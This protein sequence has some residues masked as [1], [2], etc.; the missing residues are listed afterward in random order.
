MKCI[1]CDKDVWK[2]VN[3]FIYDELDKYEIWTGLKDVFRV[4][5]KCECGLYQS[6]RNYPLADFQKI[7]TKGYRDPEF[8]GETIKQAFDRILNLPVE[9]SENTTRFKWFIHNITEK[10]GASVL[11]IGSGLGVWPYVLNVAGYDVW[12]METN[13]E[14]IEFISTD[15]GLKCVDKLPAYARF[16][17]ITCLHVLEHIEDPIEFLGTVRKM[18]KSGGE[19]FLEVPDASEFEYLDKD[20]NEFSS[21]H[22]WFF[23]ISTLNRLVEMCGFEIVHAYRPYYK[24]RR[25]SRVLTILKLKK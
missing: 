23:D 6:F 12:C 16:N 14:S 1:L 7:Y 3:G 9:D 5:K 4:W 22:V 24:E 11:D 15:L 10:T 17:I 25:L 13:K 20:H 19:L 2:A 21:D 18:L 8:R